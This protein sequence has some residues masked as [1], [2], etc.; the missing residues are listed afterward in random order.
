VTNELK[1]TGVDSARHDV[2]SDPAGAGAALEAA[3]AL[4][5]LIAGLSAA[6]GVIHLAMVPSHMNEWVAEGVAFAA[7][8]W[9]QLTTAL[10]LVV[11][12][13]R[14]LLIA[15]AT[16]NLA[17]V[18]AW[19]VTR[20]TGPPFG[21]H[22]GLAH[23]ASLVDVAT[24]AMELAVVLLAVLA[25]VRPAPG[26][27]SGA[28]ARRGGVIGATAVVVLASM[29]L[30]SPSARGHGHELAGDRAHSEADAAYGGHDTAA[31]G[32][33]AAPDGDDRGL[34]AMSNGHHHE[35]VN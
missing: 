26:L 14:R 13:S 24:A 35:M 6:A 8:G 11:R 32:E 27:L 29:V 3:A 23:E 10:L 19:V 2:A 12:P 9:L 20:T 4:R 21:P 16:A 5:Y 18:G 15:A 34:V 17:F 25:L 7:V 33:A 1:R 30:A 28:A 22:S 31:A